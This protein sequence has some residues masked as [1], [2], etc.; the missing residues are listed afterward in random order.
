[1]TR[2]QP[3]NLPGEKLVNS[4]IQILPRSWRIKKRELTESNV[5]RKT[6]KC[7]AVN[8]NDSEDHTT[9]VTAQIHQTSVANNILGAVDMDHEVVEEVLEAENSQD[10]TTNVTSVD[11]LSISSRIAQS[12]Y[13]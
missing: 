8:R 9:K 3:T 13:C 7:F 6:N 10:P 2:T 5:N 1:M 4:W 11:Q 12:K